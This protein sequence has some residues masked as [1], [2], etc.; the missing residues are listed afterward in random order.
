MNLLALSR[1]KRTY[2]F[3]NLLNS[4]RCI[5]NHSTLG[6]LV[7]TMK[8]Q[9]KHLTSP[10]RVFPRQ[11]NTISCLYYEE[12]INNTNVVVVVVK[13]CFD[14]LS[15]LTLTN[16]SLRLGRDKHCDEQKRSSDPA[17][18]PYRGSFFFASFF[19]KKS[20]FF[21]LSFN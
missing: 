9:M 5:V 18:E 17:E 1:Y 20:I 13:S 3:N 15:S 21:S 7:L 12:E 2:L 16:K 19:L 8:R 4:V 14:N 10:G 6:T 11:I